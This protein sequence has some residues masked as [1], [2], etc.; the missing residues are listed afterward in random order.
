MSV[1]WRKKVLKQDADA[2]EQSVAQALVDLEKAVDGQ[3]KAEI[4][5]LAFISASEIDAGAGKKVI[6]VVVPYTLLNNF[7]KLHHILT[8]NLEKKFR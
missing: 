1:A 4:R 8:M 2:V 3:Q 6:L 5:D 7:R